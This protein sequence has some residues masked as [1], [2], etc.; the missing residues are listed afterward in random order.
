M[1][2]T[3][4]LF[5]QSP[6]FSSPGLPLG[7]PRSAFLARRGLYCGRPGLVTWDRGTGYSQ[8]GSGAEGGG[9]GE[10][11]A[12]PVLKASARVA[13]HRGTLWC[14]LKRTQRANRA[15]LRLPARP[16]PPGSAE[17]RPRIAVACSDARTPRPSLR[18]VGETALALLEGGAR[19]GFAGMAAGFQPLVFSADRS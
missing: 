9:P 6:L 19:R 10:L 11:R 17:A 2:N 1:P 16:L 8:S 5:C 13:T 18:S 12:R 7:V 4:H 15:A 14:S 3:L